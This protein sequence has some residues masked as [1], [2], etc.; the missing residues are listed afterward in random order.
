[1]SALYVDN[2]DWFKTGDFRDAILTRPK[3]T[4]LGTKNLKPIDV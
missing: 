2:P 4:E 1:M 3:L